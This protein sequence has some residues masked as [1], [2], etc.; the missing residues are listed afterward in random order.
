MKII[1]GLGNPGGKYENNRHNAGFLLVEK[2]QKELGFPE[3]KLDKKFNALVSE[4][5]YGLK[6]KTHRLLLVKPQTFMNLSGR[7]VRSIL[8]FYKLSPADTTLVHDDLD[9]EIGN[10]KISEDSRAA[11]HN[12]VQSVFDHLGTQQ[13]KRIRIGVEKEGGRQNRKEPGDEFVLKDFSK[14]EMEKLASVLETITKE[15]I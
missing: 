9:L 11:G 7:S 14:E 10:F 1:V 2:L 13:I 15:L 12:G 8:D 4:G 6:P 5:T 3:F